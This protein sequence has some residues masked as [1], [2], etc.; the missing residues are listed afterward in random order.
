MGRLRFRTA[1]A[2][3]R[4]RGFRR[5]K[6]RGS[7]VTAEAS[8]SQPPQLSPFLVYGL[9]AVRAYDRWRLGRVAAQHPG[10]SIDPSAST[11]FASAHISLAPGA[12]L[13]IG[14]N[15]VTERRNEGVQL[16]LGRDAEL[17]IESDCWLRS[18]LGPVLLYVFDGARMH[19]GSETTLSACHLSAKQEVRVGHRS[20]VGPGSRVFDSDQH[21]RDAEHLEQ[22]APVS[23][24]DFV[25]V[26]ADV[27]V[28]R[29][30]TI[31]S[32]SVVGTRSVVTSS[33]PPHSLVAGSPAKRVGE[34]G[35]R[36]G[37]RL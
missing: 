12:K 13:S 20:G 5:R 4:V 18:D 34:V 27:S 11:N 10:F 14:S 3:D 1:P 26:T 23:I 29:G 21:D 15:V 2:R 19:I 31:G 35:D 24:E 17:V 25:W 36:S 22:T 32:H 30:V 9:Q 28:L 7:T 16:V 37:I 8:P 33:V 6:T